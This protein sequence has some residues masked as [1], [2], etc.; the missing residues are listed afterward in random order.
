MNV[1]INECNELSSV[2]SFPEYK[3]RQSLKNDLTRTDSL[4]SRLKGVKLLPSA[5]RASYCL[6]FRVWDDAAPTSV[7]NCHSTEQVALR[8]QL[9]TANINAYFQHTGLSGRSVC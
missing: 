2:P 9:A 5:V 4:L 8:L 3:V 1:Q 7:V 6:E